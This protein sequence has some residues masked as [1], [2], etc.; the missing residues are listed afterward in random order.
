[1]AAGGH[2]KPVKLFKKMKYSRNLLYIL[3]FAE[4]GRHR[5]GAE[6][7]AINVHVILVSQPISL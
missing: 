4:T 3:I 1:M 5:L 6:P 2:L 7:I